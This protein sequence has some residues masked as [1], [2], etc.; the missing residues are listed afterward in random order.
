MVLGSILISQSVE[1]LLNSN[2]SY[3]CVFLQIVTTVCLRITVT[4]I[5]SYSETTCVECVFVCVECVFVCVEC[6]FVCVWGYR[7]MCG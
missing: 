6:V 5:I 7:P 2:N 3:C 1:H 4:V